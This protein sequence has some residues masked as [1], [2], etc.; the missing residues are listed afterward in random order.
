MQI[1]KSERTQAIFPILHTDRLDLI[2]IK[3]HHLGDLYQLYSNENVTRYYNVL[4]L[5][6]EQEAQKYIDWFVSLR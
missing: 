5:K 3:Q 1:N 2:E 6:N 4:P